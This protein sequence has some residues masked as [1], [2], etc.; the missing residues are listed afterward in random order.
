MADLCILGPRPQSHIVCRDWKEEVIL[1]KHDNELFCRSKSPMHID[2]VKCRE[3]GRL[4]Y[5]S[6]VTGEGFSFSLESL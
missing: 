5:D 3:R 1:F 6:K 2:G 4:R